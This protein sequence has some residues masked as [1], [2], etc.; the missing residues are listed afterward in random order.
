MAPAQQ[1]DVQ[2]DAKPQTVTVTSTRDPVD[3]SYRK[4]IRGMERFAREH[5]LAPGAVLRF[6]LLPRTPGVN[7]HGITL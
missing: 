5:A 6:H 7:M 3:K 2:T 1:A 4:M